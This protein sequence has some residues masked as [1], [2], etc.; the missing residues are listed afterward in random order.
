MDGIHTEDVHFKQAFEVKNGKS[1]RKTEIGKYQYNSIDVLGQGYTGSVFKGTLITDPKQRFA[2]K[3][4]DLKK[5][6]KPDSLAL[7]EKEIEIHQKLKHPNII[8]CLDIYK[9]QGHY[10]I[11][12]EYCPHGDLDELLKM[13]KIVHED[14]ALKIMKQVIEAYKY[15]MGKNIIHRD[16]KPANIMRFGSVWKIGDFGFATYCTEDF[17]LDKTNLGTPLYM[18]PESLFYSKYSAKTDIFSLGVIFY[19]MLTGTTPWPSRTKK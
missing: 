16:L 8:N 3:V 14:V 15:I 13:Q 5:F 17:I 1:I 6:Q 7:V 2:I 9:S 11:M 19:E 4:I 10:F 12:T 18:P